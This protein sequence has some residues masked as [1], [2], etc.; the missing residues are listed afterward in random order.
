MYTEELVP[1]SHKHSYTPIPTPPLPL[2][3]FFGCFEVFSSLYFVLCLLS[4]GTFSFR[5]L[6]EYTKSGNSHFLTY[7]PSWWYNQP[8]LVRVGVHALPFSPIYHHKKQ[9]CGV[10]SSWEGRY[11]PLFLLWPYMYSVENTSHLNWF[12]YSVLFPYVVVVVVVYLIS[13][14]LAAMPFISLVVF[15]LCNAKFCNVGQKKM[16]D[17]YYCNLRKSSFIPVN[18]SDCMPT[19]ICFIVSNVVAFMKLVH[20]LIMLFIK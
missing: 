19:V 11:T 12:L 2:P 6:T 15:T 3:A 5:T 18:A 1:L 7:I 8:S 4:K 16:L 9:G 14:Q 10:H 13:L 17:N 20:R